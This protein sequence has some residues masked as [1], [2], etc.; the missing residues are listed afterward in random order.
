MPKM[1]IFLIF[2]LIL[3]GQSCSSKKENKQAANPFP[4]DSIQVQFK[5]FN[6]SYAGLGQL[7]AMQ[8][9]DLI[10][11]FDGNFQLAH[12]SRK[13]YKKGETIFRLTGQ[14]VEYQKSVYEDVVNSTKAERE[15]AESLLIRKKELYNQHF[16]SPEEWSEMEKNARLA[17]ISQQK[18]DSALTYFLH[19]TDFKAPFPGY[20]VDIQPQQGAYLRANSFIGRFLN[21]EKI[22][23]V[24]IWFQTGPQLQTGMSLPLVFNDSA[25]VS[26]KIS[27]L[28]SAIDPETGGREIWFELLA[29]VPD[30]F[31]GQWVQYRLTTSPHKMLAVPSDALLMENHEYWVMILLRHI[32]TTQRV[33][34]GTTKNGWVEIKSGLNEGEWVVTQ[35]AYELFYKKSKI[36]YKAED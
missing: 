11:Q 14:A 2:L 18:A 34:I 22:K 17:Q 35:G 24:G 12:P 25:L 29:P 9:T 33:S 15:Y 7:Q 28:E 21:P 30:Y 10:V 1:K 6:E 31:S 20:L 26:S 36:K 27:Y 23:L 3:S 32:P 13:Y 8:Q 4:I 5:E 16:V 19:Q